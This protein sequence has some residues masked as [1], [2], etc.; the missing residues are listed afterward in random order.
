MNPRTTGTVCHAALVAAKSPLVARVPVGGGGFSG[1]V[2]GM[3]GLT[4]D[5]GGSP[6]GRWDMTALLGFVAVPLLGVAGVVAWAMSVRDRLPDPIARHFNAAGEADGFGGL[7]GILVM[8]I[9]V[10][11][12]MV[13]LMGLLGSWRRNPRI[14]RRMLGPASP[15]FAGFMCGLL[16]DTLVPQ[17]DLASAVGVTSGSLWTVAGTT[18]GLVVGVVTA[19]AL[20]DPPAPV[21][22]DA[23]DPSLPRGPRVEPIRV[24]ASTGVKLLIAA[25]FAGTLASLLISPAL[26][27]LLALSSFYIVQMHSVRVRVDDAGVHL[28]MLLGET[29]PLETITAARPARYDWGDSGGVGIRGVG[30]RGSRGKRIAVAARSGEA[31]DVDTTGHN[32]T[33]VVPDGAAERIAGDINARLDARPGPRP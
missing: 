19:M 21:A 3:D 22:T 17:L 1:I 11:L 12:P 10:T 9:V 2:A 4:T 18:L 20:T 28:R 26:F 5:R 23:P 31:L 6:T 25:W 16:P 32:W 30:Y 15:V 27:L 29:I 7:T 24:E 8:T 14:I 13:L 33:I